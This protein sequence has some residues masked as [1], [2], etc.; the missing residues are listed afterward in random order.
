MECLTVQ[1]ALEAYVDGDLDPEEARSLELHLADCASCQKALTRLQAVEE[2]LVTWP[3]VVEPASLTD[4][5]MVRVRTRA[6]MPP[7]RLH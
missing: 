7:F 3:L 4:E 2:A 1:T 6:P 5:I